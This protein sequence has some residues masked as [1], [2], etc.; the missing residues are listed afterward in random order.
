[1]PAATN[2]TRALIALGLG[3]SFLL[4]SFLIRGGPASYSKIIVEVNETEGDKWYSHGINALAEGDYDLATARFTSAIKAYTRL[5]SSAKRRY[6]ADIWRTIETRGWYMP[7]ANWDQLVDEWLR[8]L[9]KWAQAIA[10]RGEAYSRKGQFQEA[11]ADC[12]EALRLG[13][14]EETETYRVR[15]ATYRAVGETAKAEWDERQAEFKRRP[16][17]AEKQ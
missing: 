9:G 8:N 6:L 17:Q 2:R 12:T 7:R 3:L 5:A 14:D 10:K 4:A 15:A 13:L 16:K 1:M 11:I